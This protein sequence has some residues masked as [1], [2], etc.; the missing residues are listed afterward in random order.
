MSSRIIAVL[1]AAFLLWMASIY[2]PSGSGWAAFFT[3]PSTLGR[4]AE[5]VLDM[6]LF[7][8]A[9]AFLAVVAFQAV[10]RISMTGAPVGTLFGAA[11]W[12]WSLM[13]FAI[14]GMASISRPAVI[15]GMALGL[16]I[17]AQVYAVSLPKGWFGL[18]YP[19]VVFRW[20]RRA[21]AEFSSTVRMNEQARRTRSGSAA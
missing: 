13:L 2:S 19:R 18:R 8:G 5:F 14:N 9:L 17:S 4:K 20:N 15:G 7:P 16:A 21:V 12:A 6:Y 11:V 10:Q 1:G 3:E